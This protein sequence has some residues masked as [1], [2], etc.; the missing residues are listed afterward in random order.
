MCSHQFRDNIGFYSSP[1]FVNQH[2]PSCKTAPT[3]SLREY[4]IALRCE[5]MQRADVAI[6]AGA[7]DTEYFFTA[8]K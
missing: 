3:E 1:R 4:D 7:V 8:L 6:G 2:L 5:A